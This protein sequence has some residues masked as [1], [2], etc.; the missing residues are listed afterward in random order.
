MTKSKYQKRYHPHRY[1]PIVRFAHLSIGGI[2]CW[3]LAK[4]SEEIHHVRYKDQYG[5]I[6]GREIPGVDIFPVCIKCHDSECH[7]KENWVIAKV[8]PELNNHSTEDA[9]ERLKIGY[10]L[11]SSRFSPKP[12]LTPIK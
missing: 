2:C 3:C 5:A 8:K 4:P 12:C 7:S 9:V 6:A 11:L 1:P 10:E